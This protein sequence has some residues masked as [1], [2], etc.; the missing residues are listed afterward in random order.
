[1]GRRFS[2]LFHADDGRKRAWLLPRAAISADPAVDHLPD[3]A[4]LVV[5]NVNRAVRPAPARP[6][7]V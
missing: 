3:A 6:G 2:H 1:M 4:A 7:G 5:G